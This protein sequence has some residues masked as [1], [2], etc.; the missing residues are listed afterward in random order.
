MSNSCPFCQQATAP[1]DSLRDHVWSFPHALSVL[2]RWQFYHGYCV[3][4]SRMHAREPDDLSLAERDGLTESMWWMARAIREA[5]VPRKLN[6]ELL[7][8]QVEHPHWH[9]FP[10]LASDP[11]HLKPAWV[12]IDREEGQPGLLPGLEGN[13]A[14][15]SAT[16][17]TLKATLARLGA[18]SA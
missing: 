16:I 8:N 1:A 17:A 12:R 7:G 14:S 18:P 3:V 5:F 11:E 10:R 13:Q 9:I 2:G 15:R 6:Y 4:F